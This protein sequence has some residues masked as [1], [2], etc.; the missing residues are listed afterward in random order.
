M[1]K[2]YLWCP[3]CS[4][5]QIYLMEVAGV[6]RGFYICSNCNRVWKR[7]RELDIISSEWRWHDY[8]KKMGISPS[9]MKVTKKKPMLIVEEE[10]PDDQPPLSKEYL[11]CPQCAGNGIMERLSVKS[12]KEEIDACDECDLTWEKG[13]LFQGDGVGLFHHYI[14]KKGIPLSKTEIT[15]RRRLIIMEEDQV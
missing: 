2:E 4:E 5:G 1:G 13:T 8:L 9:N 11:L 14:E 6:K 12:L 10:N 15:N 3:N 7:Y